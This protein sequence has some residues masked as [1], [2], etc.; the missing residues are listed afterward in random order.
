MIA[1]A[2]LFLGLF[3]GARPVTLLV[4]APVAAVTVEL[5]GNDVGKLAAAPWT[6]DVDFG[7]EFAPHELVA[8]GF[9]DK[10][11]EVAAVRQWVNL[12]RPAAE[13]EI[14]IERDA[15]GRAAAARLAWESVLGVAPDRVTV[16]FDGKPLELSADRRVALPSFDAAATH[17]LTAALDFPNDVR[18][19]RDVVLGGGSAGEA[20]TELTA[21]PVLTENGKAPPLESLRGALRRGEAPLTVAAVERAPA[22]VYLVRDLDCADGQRILK[23][24]TA[25]A[26]AAGFG[27]PGHSDVALFRDPTLLDAD[28]RVRILWPVARQ[29]VE[30]GVSNELFDSSHEFTGNTNGFRFLLTRVDYPGYSDKPR[31]FA[32]AVALA[33]VRAFSSYSRRAVVLVLGAR[34]D[35]SRYAADAV[36][37]YLERLH[38]PLF[39]WCLAPESTRPKETAAWGVVED[40][41]TVSG[42]ER[43]VDKLRKSLDRQSIVW[44]EGRYLPQEIALSG[45]GAVVTLA[46]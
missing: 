32:D 30:K 25:R 36:R 3:V 18:A 19:R 5:D 8:R 13:I 23:R 10:G 15:K 42:L 29:A 37:R 11:T 44:V 1:F 34:K 46:R 6:L 20:K 26:G 40:A 28:D 21:V 17:V 4:G 14:V 7:G 24:F 38:V 33:G 12:P 31:R 39:V 27:M 45:S 9:D 43:A 35:E 22:E 16:T 2:T 41:T